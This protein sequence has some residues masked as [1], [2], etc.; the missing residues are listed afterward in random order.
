MNS[1][2]VT[3]AI[4]KNKDKY[5]I[6]KRPNDGR[7]KSNYWEFP[8]G[9]IEFGESPRTCIE[10]EIK[11]EL[12]IVIKAKDILDISSYVYDNSKHILLVGIYCDY[13]CGNIQK[14]DIESFE[15]VTKDDM[16]NYMIC[17]ADIPF[18]NKL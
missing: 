8:G 2:L 18:I 7:H 13:I 6:T 15:W 12:G 14:L 5:L 16:I 11:E 3:A 4:I 9:K 10:R 1:I 17:E